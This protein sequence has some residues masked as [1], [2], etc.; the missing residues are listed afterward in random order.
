MQAKELSIVSKKCRQNAG[1]SANESTA[2]YKAY[3]IVWLNDNPS[4]K[5]KSQVIDEIFDIS[6]LFQF[7]IIQIKLNFID[8]SDCQSRLHHLFRLRFQV[9]CQ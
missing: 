1:S 6:S 9:A 2:K 3:L 4:E 8:F 5:R 7:L